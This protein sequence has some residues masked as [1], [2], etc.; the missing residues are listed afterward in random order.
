MTS[1][2]AGLVTGLWKRFLAKGPFDV[3]VWVV[4]MAALVYLMFRTGGALL[5]ISVWSVPFVL[6]IAAV[7]TPWRSVKWRTVASFF[8]IGF[9]PVF[10]LTALVA[11]SLDASGVEDMIRRG[12]NSMA[13]SGIDLRLHDVRA[14]VIAPVIEE[15]FKVLPLLLIFWWRRSGFRTSAGPL[16]YA[17][18]AGA[19]G[20][21]LGF[22]EDIFV[23]LHQGLSGPT[24]SIF[25]LGLGPIYARLVGVENP[26]F[27]FTGRSRFAD[28]AAFFF[29]EMQETLGFVWS[30][31]GALAL[32]TGLALGLAVWWSRRQGTRWFYLVPVA[33][34]LWTMVEHMLNNWYGGAGCGSRPSPLCTVASV[35]LH[36]RV[37]PLVVLAGWGYAMWVT[38][39]Q[40]R[41]FRTIDQDLA[42]PKG[43]VNRSAYP[44]GWRGWIRLWS[45]RFDFH[46]LRRKTAYGAFHLQARKV[47]RGQAAS[48]LATRVET[49]LVKAR[50]QGSPTTP[51]GEETRAMIDRAAPIP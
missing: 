8:M 39:R 16:D 26:G 37:L 4:A 27:V 21:G 31:H 1:P 23:H 36:G 41:E 30:G 12:L 18:L 14:D 11:W 2:E 51:L 20:A 50:L 49:L 25:G 46:R 22:A 40:S 10:L 48:V 35:D 3:T 43:S 44:S 24:S 15:L 19:T 28:T 13:T 45:D 34:L 38:G 9:G 29:P 42:L 6:M 7:S 32:G 47:T 5:R 17:V 33:V